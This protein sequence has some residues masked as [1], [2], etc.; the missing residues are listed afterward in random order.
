MNVAS[1][2]PV[3]TG[4][5]MTNATK[6][7]QR[8]DRSSKAQRQEA[9][10]RTKR[11]RTLVFGIIGLVAVVVIAAILLTSGGSSD[12]PPSAVGQV[13]IAPT[14]GPVQAGDSIPAFSAPAL[15]GGTM[16]WSA[17]AGK[18]TVLAIWAP[19]CPHCQAELP[20]LSEAMAAHPDLQLVSVATAIGQEPGP[21]V[22]GYL[23]DHGLTFPV[24]VDDS[25]N[26]ILNGLGVNS[27][28]TLFY[29]DAGGKVV[30]VTTGE[31][32]PDQLNAAL[33][34]LDA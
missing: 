22:A 33:D 19:W 3:P 27:F 25:R 31:L 23:K 13:S 4:G 20:R 29:V 8:A 28:P 9:E 6:A 32:S 34:Q 30:R 17:Y 15:G 24:G 14:S 18:P 16:D 12:T 26:T 7:K 11:Q 2:L 21:S 10:R 5:S 1:V